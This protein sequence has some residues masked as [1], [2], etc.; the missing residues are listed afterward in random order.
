MTGQ[1]EA[2]D[3][4]VLAPAEEDSLL[5]GASWHRLVVLGDSLAEATLGDPVPGYERLTWPERLARAL[6]RQAHDLE[7]R[8][9]GRRH[10]TAGQVAEQQLDDALSF[11]PDLA[12]VICGG[13]DVLVEE[14]DRERTK[15]DI[16]RIVTALRGA[17]SDVVLLTTFD[18]AGVIPVPEPY[19]G[20][21]AERMP[22]LHADLRALAA[23]QSGVVLVDL[24][25]HPRGHDRGIFS[26]DGIHTNDAG[27]A[28]IASAVIRAIGASLQHRV[29]Q[30]T[31][32]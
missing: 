15:G 22:Q 24:A 1:H 28:V 25:Q 27:Q 11:R 32:S 2:A 30:Q 20:R 16:A 13:N 6:R 23:S 26:A 14:F 8:N 29:D 18:T 10:R 31:R 9:V 12:C 19:A 17:G 21:I 5:Q 4:D 7:Y 3:K